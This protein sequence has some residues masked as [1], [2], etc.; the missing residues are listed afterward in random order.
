MNGLP[1]PNAVLRLL[2][3]D[4]KRQCVEGKCAC[5]VIDI[6]CTDMCSLKTYDNQPFEGVVDEKDGQDEDEIDI[7]EN[8]GDKNFVID[9]D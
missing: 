3:C 8:E 1:A 5:M 9:F 6:K 2:P 7:D 4:S